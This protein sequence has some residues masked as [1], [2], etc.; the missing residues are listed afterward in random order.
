MTNYG[1]F[2]AIERRFTDEKLSKMGFK[3]T[4][5]W[6]MKKRWDDANKEITEKS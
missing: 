2:L 1:L 5:V 6:R 4:S 3:K